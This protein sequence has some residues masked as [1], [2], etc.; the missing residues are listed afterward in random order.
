VAG[1]KTDAGICMLCGQEKSGTPAQADFVIGTVRKLRGTLNLPGKRTI[2]CSQCLPECKKR[3]AEFEKKLRSHR[4]GAGIF[5]LILVAGS[6]AYAG[7]GLRAVLAG[8]AGAALI[9]LLPYAKYFPE[10]E[11]AD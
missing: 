1:R 9:A 3:R 5:F 11:S 6:I 10:F 8:L 2:A 4:I 7:F